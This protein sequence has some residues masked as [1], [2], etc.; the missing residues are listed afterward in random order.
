M[1]WYHEVPA[2]P[3]PYNKSEPTWEWGDEQG[4]SA[5]RHSGETETSSII[6]PSLVWSPVSTSQVLELKMCTTLGPLLIFSQSI[7]E[8]RWISMLHSPHVIWPLLEFSSTLLWQWPLICNC[9]LDQTC[10]NRVIWTTGHPLSPLCMLLGSWQHAQWAHKVSPQ[11]LGLGCP[12]GGSGIHLDAFPREENSSASTFPS[13]IAWCSQVP[14][15][16]KKWQPVS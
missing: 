6:L 14:F 2:F 3:S 16:S 4:F 11:L 5:L 10:N 15:F 1:D 13:G 12:Q 9:P 8:R 7:W